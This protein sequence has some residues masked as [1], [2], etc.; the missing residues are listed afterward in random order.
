ME[1]LEITSFI[2][3]AFREWRGEQYIP[4]NV[5]PSIRWS[6]RSP[7]LETEALNL[8]E[9]LEKLENMKQKKKKTEN[10]QGSLPATKSYDGI[11]SAPDVNKSV[12]GKSSTAKRRRSSSNHV[13]RPESR[14]ASSTHR[15]LHAAMK[16]KIEQQSLQTLLPHA[17]HYKAPIGF[18]WSQNSC[19]YDS[20]FTLLFVLWCSNR[21]YW[22]LS[23]SGMGNAVA[24]LLLEGFSLYERGKAYISIED[25]C[26]HTLLVSTNTVISERYYECPNGHH[27]HHSNDYDAFLSAGVHAYGSIAQ[28]VSTETHHAYARCH[29]CA[30]KV[31]LKLRFCC[32]PPLLV[33]SI[34]QLSIHIDTAFKIVVEN[35]DHLYT[36]AAVIY[37]ANSHF[38]AQIITRDG[39]VWFY[40]GMQIIDPNIQPTLEYV[41]TIHSQID[42]RVCRGG[43]ASALIYAASCL[44]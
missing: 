37:Y 3:V 30:H 29:I 4:Q 44:Y 41:G 11:L 39:R 34:F 36:L 28:W 12:Q 31:G 14:K 17:G 1:T 9:R 10:K 22:A 15:G 19:A 43:G 25:V 38:T 21:E 32:S 26:E 16:W 35:S 6:K 23:I 2:I 33:F 13:Q 27:V 7:W 5:H 18:R 24:D 42:M 20:F 8:D 40:D